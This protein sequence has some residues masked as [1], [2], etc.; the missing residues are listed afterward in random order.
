MSDENRVWELTTNGL[1]E[2]PA[3]RA[4]AVHP[5]KPETVYV[6]TQNGPYKSVDH[7]DHWE[8]VAIPDHGLQF[9]VRNLP[10]STS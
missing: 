2:A 8:S 3:V 1:P 6:G 9:D 10:Q 7:G 5:Q 4:I